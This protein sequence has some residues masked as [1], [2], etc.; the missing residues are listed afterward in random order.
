MLEELMKISDLQLLLN[1]K[2][3]IFKYFTFKSKTSKID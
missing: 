3:N 1:S 2:S